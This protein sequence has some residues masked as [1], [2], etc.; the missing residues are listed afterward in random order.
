[1]RKKITSVKKNLSMLKI[2]KYYKF[3]DH[4]HYREKYR[5]DV[6]KMCNLR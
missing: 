2:K 1:M 6:H 3:R 4:C 5:D